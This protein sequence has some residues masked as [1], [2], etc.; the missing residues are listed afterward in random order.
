ML[1]VFGN[2]E[3][4]SQVPD[5]ISLNAKVF[6]E[7]ETELSADLLQCHCLSCLACRVSPCSLFRSLPF[8][9]QERCACHLCSTLTNRVSPRVTGLGS[10]LEREDDSADT[11]ETCNGQI[12]LLS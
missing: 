8:A 11:R 7:S 4:W 1:H 2:L 9:S 12:L 10:E 3:L 6:V 5:N